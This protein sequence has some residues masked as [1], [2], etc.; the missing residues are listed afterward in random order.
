V[1]QVASFVFTNYYYR[2]V[3]PLPFALP[4]RFL[5]FFRFGFVPGSGWTVGEPKFGVVDVAKGVE[6]GIV[7][8]AKEDPPTDG[9][10]PKEG[11]AREGVVL[12]PV[13][14]FVTNI[15]ELVVEG[16]VPNR[17]L[18]V[19]GVD[20]NREEPAVEGVELNIEPVEGVELNIEPVEGVPNKEEEDPPC[21]GVAPVGTEVTAGLIV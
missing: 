1:E 2:F 10:V 6:E 4:V 8:G 17:E 18:V 13:C 7:N 3:L 5:F 16:V 11:V 12:P 14:G 19:D 9:V 15:V 20:A 21:V